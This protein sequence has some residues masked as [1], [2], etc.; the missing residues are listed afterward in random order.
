M[1]VSATSS[2]AADD[3]DLIKE[4]KSAIVSGLR[5]PDSAQFWNVVVRRKKCVQPTVCHDDSTAEPN[6]C[7]EVNAKNGYGGYSGFQPFI[8]YHPGPPITP[9]LLPGAFETAYES[10]CGK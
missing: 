10:S 7:G 6:V 9:D 8:Y 1:N 4:A 5:D 3:S 2:V